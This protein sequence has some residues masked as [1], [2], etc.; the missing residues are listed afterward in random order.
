MNSKKRTYPKI[1]LAVLFSLIV[2]LAVIITTFISA[3]SSYKAERSILYNRTL[4]MNYST[5]LQMSRTL[6]T[7]FKSMR[8]G[9]HTVSIHLFDADEASQSADIQAKLDFFKNSNDYFNSVFWADAKGVV[10]SIASPNYNLAGTK[11]V[12]TPALEALATRKSTLS[13]PYTGTSGRLII[14]MTEPVFDRN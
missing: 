13:K 9:L 11:L 2:G 12:S 7:L 3:A 10:R 6:G 5:S 8:L 14:L 4:E 1:R